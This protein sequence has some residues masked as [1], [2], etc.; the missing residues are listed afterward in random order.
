MNSKYKVYIDMDGVIADFD[1]KVS[2]IT[3]NKYGLPDFP[4]GKM[5]SAIQRYDAD[6]EPFYESLEKMPGADA[7]VDFAT[8]NFSEVAILTA[9]GFTPK[10]VVEQKGKW[11]K[12]NY[13]GM[14]LITVTKSPEKAIYANPRAILIDDREKAIDPWKKAGG[15]GILFTSSGQAIGELKRFI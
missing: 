15:I 6:V 1:A 2:E 12:V 5:W 13:P 3:N 9:T 4:T 11:I 7:L 10:N 14:K 8:S